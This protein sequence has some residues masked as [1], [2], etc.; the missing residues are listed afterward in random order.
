MEL[1]VPAYRCPRDPPLRID[2]I[3][4]QDHSFDLPERNRTKG[5]HPKGLSDFFAPAKGATGVR[6][7][8]VVNEDAMNQ[9]CKLGQYSL[10]NM[11]T[12]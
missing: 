8:H 7:F 3:L 10:Q 12:V 6:K 1:L 9:V 4:L 11:P 2:S 5:K